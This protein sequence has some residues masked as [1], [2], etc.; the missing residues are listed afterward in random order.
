MLKSLG[1]LVILGDDT[2]ESRPLERGAVILRLAR[3]FQVSPDPMLANRLEEI[4]KELQRQ[5]E[6]KKRADEFSDQH[7][8]L[9]NAPVHTFQDFFAPYKP[10]V[11]WGVGTTVVLACFL[12]VSVSARWLRKSRN[13]SARSPNL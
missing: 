2:Y 8:H 13:A 6:L 11:F 10:Y 4:P 3:E 12:I 5:V 7:A 9:T 1:Y